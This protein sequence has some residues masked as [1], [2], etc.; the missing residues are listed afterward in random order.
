[1]KI[2]RTLTVGGVVFLALLLQAQEPPL[3]VTVKSLEDRTKRGT[4][5]DRRE[6]VRGD[7]GKWNDKAT[8][9]HAPPI[10]QKPSGMLLDDW[11]DELAGK[12]AVTTAADDNW[13]IFRSR[14]FDDNDRV[15][16]E[17]IERRG[18]AFTVELNEATWQGKYF[19]SF[20]YYEVTAVNLG[21]LP[22]GTYTVKWLVKPLTFKQL[23]KPAQPNRDNKDNWPIDEQPTGAKPVE[24]QAAFSVP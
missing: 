8:L 15:W 4:L 12:K 20:T 19:K 6:F 11:A 17:K 1:V 21:P 23:E 2:L 3:T 14:Q 10:Q 18:H 16:I 7:T 13:L 22:P 5:S 24:L 9:Q